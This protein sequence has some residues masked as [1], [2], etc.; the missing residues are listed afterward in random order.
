MLLMMMFLFHYKYDTYILIVKSFLQIFLG[1]N[2]L[3]IDFH[4]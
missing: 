2:T 4:I 3:L 1:K